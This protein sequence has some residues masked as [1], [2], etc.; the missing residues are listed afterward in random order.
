M[1]MQNVR[2]IHMRREKELE[3]SMRQWRWLLFDI[4]FP[5]KEKEMYR[6]NACLKDCCLL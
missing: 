2:R 5:K 3:H 4:H 6:A 1:E